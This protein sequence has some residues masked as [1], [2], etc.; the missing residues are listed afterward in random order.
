MKSTE[1]GGDGTDQQRTSQTTKLRV[2]QG[3]KFC[4]D[5][6]WAINFYKLC[7][8]QGL[9]TVNTYLCDVQPNESYYKGHYKLLTV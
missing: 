6:G 1:E 9:K 5:Q 7:S 4:L 3:P 8:S 2:F